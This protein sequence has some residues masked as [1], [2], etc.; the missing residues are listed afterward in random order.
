MLLSDLS[1][2]ALTHLE[3]AVNAVQNPVVYLAIDPGGSNGVCGYDTRFHVLFMYT[4]KSDDMVEFLAQF[5]S[6]TKCI[7]EN[8]V[9]YPNHKGKV[10]IPEYSDMETSRVIGRVES[11]AKQYNVELVKQL[12]TIKETGYKWIGKKPLPKSNPLNHEWDAHVH[13]MYWAI[14]NNHISAASILKETK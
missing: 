11:W 6:V 13:F 5:K 10:R 2:E 7:I 3:N 8:F 9:K 14:R 4:V 1:P 12:A